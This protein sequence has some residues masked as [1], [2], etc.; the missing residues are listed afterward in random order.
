MPK[1]STF[2]VP[3]S[4]SMM[5]SG[6]RS[7]WTIPASCAHGERPRH[8]QHQLRRARRRHAGAPPRVLARAPEPGRQRLARHVLEHHVRQPLVLGDVVERDDV[9]VRELRR[10]ARLDE[11]A[12]AVL[13]RRPR[14]GT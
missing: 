11:E 7:R 9:L 8:R 6:L 13:R 1:S 2:T 14:A 5:L 4:A 3:L 10:R 12:R